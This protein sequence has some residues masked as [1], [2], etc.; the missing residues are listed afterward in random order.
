MR[1]RTLLAKHAWLCVVRTIIP[2]AASA[3]RA[4]G[5]VSI[6]AKIGHFFFSS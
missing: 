3:V 1:I 5:D 2:Y 6:Y 4:P